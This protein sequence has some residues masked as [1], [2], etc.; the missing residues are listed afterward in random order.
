M[1]RRDFIKRTSLGAMALSLPFGSHALGS[2]DQINLGIIGLGSTVKIG[3]KGK[4]DLRGF[5]KIPGV[6]IAAICDCDELILQQEAKALEKEDI[7]VKTYKDFR[8]LLDDKEIDAVSIATPNHSHALITVMACQ[9][10]KHV[11][12]Q[13]PASHNIFE[14]RKMVEAARKYK[15]IVQVPHVPRMPLGYKEA[16][17]WAREGH[18]GKIEY[19][20]GLNYRARMSIG[21]VAAPTAIPDSVDYNLWA[22]PAPM[23]KIRR[24]NFHY[25]WHW[26]WN[27]GNGDLGNNGIHYLDGCRMALGLDYLPD[28]VMSIGGRFG[29]DDDGQTPNTQIVYYDYGEAPAIF[30]VRGLPMNS[31]Y[32]E[33]NWAARSRISMD[34]C[35]GVKIGVLV[36]CKDGYT[37]NN[38]AFDHSGRL[39]KTFES[40]Y[41]GDKE[42]FINAL[43]KND[44][45]HLYAD[46]EQGHLSSALIHM[47]NA[48]YRIGKKSNPGEIAERIKGRACL[49][50]SFDRFATHL[51]ANKIDWDKE[52]VI[53]GPMLEFNS[54][55]AQFVGEHAAEANALITREYREPFVVP[56]KV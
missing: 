12:C 1:E 33:S 32:R 41:E 27:T 37:A 20:H 35:L 7:R 4:M 56:E 46:V 2:N 23:E 15:R 42:N 29:Y 13:K 6:R 47:G 18:L 22:G 40:T 16:F 25:D 24:E 10:G 44:P 54:D 34:D 19:V 17:D 36:F 14:G 55:S 9:A 28:K 51:F 43:W 11:Y 31:Y 30:E 53:L 39:L 52:D 3:G 8:D 50:E 45:G 26:D 49:Q 21:K 48:S 38:Q 5:A